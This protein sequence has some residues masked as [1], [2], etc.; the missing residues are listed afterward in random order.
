M[1]QGSSFLATLG[2]VTNPLREMDVNAAPRWFH[3]CA[4]RMGARTAHS[5]GGA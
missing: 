2:F 3:R 1:D 4:P 5:E